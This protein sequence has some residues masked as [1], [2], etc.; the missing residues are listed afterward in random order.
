MDNKLSKLYTLL[1][2]CLEV[3][4]H[5]LRD[6]YWRP[7]VSPETMSEV[8]DLLTDLDEELRNAD[9]QEG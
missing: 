7:T 3:Q 9:L 6:C 5:I 1:E 2:K 4:K 8:Q